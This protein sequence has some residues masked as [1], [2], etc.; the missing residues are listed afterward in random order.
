[1]S[2]RDLPARIAKLATGLLLMALS[3]GCTAKASLGI[4]PIASVPYVMELSF[5]ISLGCWTVLFSLFLFVIQLWLYRAKMP[6]VFLLQLPTAG[7][8]GLFTD[9]AMALLSG[10]SLA[11]LASQIGFLAAGCLFLALG[12]KLET[13]ASLTMLPGEATAQA[14]AT[15]AK[16]P[17]GTAKVLTD[18]SMVLSAGLLSLLF[19]G[20]IQGIGIGT[21]VAA[22]S[23]G[24]LCRLFSRTAPT[25]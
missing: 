22:V 6:P 7:V 3:V 13:A 23:V 2:T 16:L 15:A 20:S 25:A 24:S 14:V 10:V 4:S 19:L 5:P 21:I 17:F 18:L 1:M 12:V 11:G 9:S 8:F